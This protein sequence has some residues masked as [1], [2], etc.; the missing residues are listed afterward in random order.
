[1]TKENHLLASYFRRFFSGV[2]LSRISGFGR[3]LSMALAFGDHPSVAAFLI[4]YRFSNLMRRLFAEGP[5][6]STFIPYFEGLRTQDENRA[7]F[8]FTK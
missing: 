8:F 4:A 5:F 2:L 7:L 3:D 6:Q 1:M